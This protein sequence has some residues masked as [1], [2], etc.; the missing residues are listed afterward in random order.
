MISLNKSNS[1]TSRMLNRKY[2]VTRPAGKKKLKNLDWLDL[3][4][5]GAE[6][7]K[8]LTEKQAAWGNFR[9]FFQTRTKKQNAQERSK[10]AEI[11]TPT[12]PYKR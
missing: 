9:R 11:K 12:N 7:S 4:S 5:N 10:K 1:N 2:D 6:K 8:K 3:I